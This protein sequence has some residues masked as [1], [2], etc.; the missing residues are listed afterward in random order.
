MNNTEI[1]DK[2]IELAGQLKAEPPF[3][4]FIV[5]KD[6]KDGTGNGYADES[7]YLQVDDDS[8]FHFVGENGQSRGLLG[9]GW[10][11]ILHRLADGDWVR[12]SKENAEARV[13]KPVHFDSAF[14]WIGFR[15]GAATAGIRCA[16][17]TQNS[18]KDAIEQLQAQFGTASKGAVD[19]AIN[20]AD[21]LD[22]SGLTI[23]PKDT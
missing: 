23:P 21:R 12:V 7:A 18:E 17:D 10:A 2:I 8:V 19:I 9:W 13:R 16:G 3:P 15:V 6:Y 20:L 4:W 11:K 5:H 22:L 1:I 14:T